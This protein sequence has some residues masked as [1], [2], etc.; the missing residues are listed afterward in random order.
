MPEAGGDCI[1]FRLADPGRDLEAVALVQEVARPRVGPS[2]IR[3]A[4]GADWVVAL[5]IPEVD[6]LEYLFEVHRPGGAV[7]T[8][9]DA[10]NQVRAAGPFGD[11][12]VIELAGYRPPTWLAEPPAP[13]GTISEVLVHS[14]VLRRALH[15]VLWTSAGHDHDDPLPLLVVHDGVEYALYSGLLA[16]L[17]RAV[18]HGRLPPMHAA[19]LVPSRRNSDY[20]AS[21]GYARALVEEVI[22]EV[23]RHLRTPGDASTRVAMG[24][25]LGG[26]AM[27][28]AHRLHP[29]T[30]GALFLQ[31]SS[32]FLAGLDDHESWLTHHPRIV[33]FVRG[34]LDRPAERPIPVVMTCG[35][36][37]EN[38]HGN[39]AVAAALTQGGY[40]V[41]LETVRDAHNWT[42]WRDTF[43]PHLAALLNRIWS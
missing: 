33:R 11:K 40:P 35:L 8:I 2:F 3:L 7:E 18:A 6:R 41:A 34:V 19:L 25:S 32:L 29:D 24:A 36:V 22:P 4:N 16:F 5:P 26:L 9:T 31:S 37:E 1:E 43:D 27:L 15:A 12:S 30:F 13:S 17:D 20:S 39:R 10:T 28:H 42:A 38:L 14:A 23:E 21:P